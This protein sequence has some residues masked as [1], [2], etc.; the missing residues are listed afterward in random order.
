MALKAFQ[1]GQTVV[2]S[3]FNYNVPTNPKLTTETGFSGDKRL[4]TV[5]YP[6]DTSLDTIT[7]FGSSANTSYSNLET[8][9]GFRIKCY[10]S[11]SQ[12]GIQFNPTD[13]DNINKVFT[14]N[15]YYVLIHADDEKQTSPRQNYRSSNYGCVRR[16]F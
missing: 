8:T 16:W 7:E 3:V 9:E 4:F 14:T 6:D 1:T 11:A 13:W 10:D 15:D 5:I 12:E 2:S